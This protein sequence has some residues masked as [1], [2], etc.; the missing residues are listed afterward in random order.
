MS[1]NADKVA[2]R[3]KKLSDASKKAR[4][5][6]TLV[7]L[8]PSDGS[9]GEI[10]DLYAAHWRIILALY[11]DYVTGFDVDF[12]AGKGRQLNVPEVTALRS[13][14]LNLCHFSLP[15]MPKQ[16]RDEFLR[17]LE[18]EVHCFLHADNHLTVRR[19]GLELL[20]EW[21]EAERDP[22]VASSQVDPTVASF[23]VSAFDWEYFRTG[24]SGVV[25]PTTVVE[26]RK[27]RHRSFP[28]KARQTIGVDDERERGALEMLRNCFDRGQRVERPRWVEY[29]WAFFVAY[30]GPIL[31]PQE[32]FEARVTNRQLLEGFSQGVPPKIHAVVVQYLLR[33]AQ[34]RERIEKEKPGTSRL[35]CTEADARVVQLLLA[36]TPSITS[37]NPSDTISTVGALNLLHGWMHDTSI[38]HASAVVSD[39]LAVALKD[40]Q[41]A[42]YAVLLA[43]AE[44]EGSSTTVQQLAE[45]VLRLLVSVV[46]SDHQFSDDV[47]DTALLQL[48]VLIEKLCASAADGNAFAAE[49]LVLSCRALWA[50]VLRHASPTT[51]RFAKF[52]LPVA[53]RVQQK[54]RAAAASNVAC[55]FFHCWG[56]ILKTSSRSLVRETPKFEWPAAEAAPREDA[57]PLASQQVR[58]AIKSRLNDPCI[59]ERSCE[60]D[61]AFDFFNALLHETMTQ[62]A[63]DTPAARE[64]KC[65]ALCESTQIICQAATAGAVDLEPRSLVRLLAP[66]LLAAASSHVEGR[67]HSNLEVLAIE[68]TAMLMNLPSPTDEPVDTVLFAGLL[69]VVAG[70]LGDTNKSGNLDLTRRVLLALFPVSDGTTCF[71]EHPHHGSRCYEG[72][73]YQGADRLLETKTDGNTFAER[74]QASALLC[75]VWQI[76]FARFSPS[77]SPKVDGAEHLAKYQNFFKSAP[78]PACIGIAVRGVASLAEW[79]LEGVSDDDRWSQF[80]ACVELITTLFHHTSVRVAAATSSV[81]VSVLELARISVAALSDEMRSSRERDLG[82]VALVPTAGTVLWHLSQWNAEKPPSEAIVHQLRA[83]SSGVILCG[84]LDVALSGTTAHTIAELVCD[85]IAFSKSGA[86]AGQYA[87]SDPKPGEIVVV[88]ADEA[89]TRLNVPP[90]HTAIPGLSDA[91]AESPRAWFVEDVM[92]GEGEAA[93][94]DVWS[95]TDVLLG[96]LKRL[97]GNSNERFSTV[98]RMDGALVALGLNNT[99]ITK[100]FTGVRPDRLIIEA[101]TAH[102]VNS[103]QAEEVLHRQ[104]PKETTDAFRHLSA[105]SCSVALPADDALGHLLSASG[106]SGVEAPQPDDAARLTEDHEEGAQA[107][108]EPFRLCPPPSCDSR[109][110]ANTLLFH[111]GCFGTDPWSRSKPLSSGVR[112]QRHSALLGN[113]STDALPPCKD[114]CVITISH[115]VRDSA[116][117][118]KASTATTQLAEALGKREADDTFRWTSP[119]HEVVTV[120]GPMNACPSEPTGAETI[121]V[122]VHV[123]WAASLSMANAVGRVFRSTSSGG[124]HR[125]V[126]IVLTPTPGGAASR[127][128]HVFRR[129][130]ANVAPLGNAVPLPLPALPSFIRSA[131]IAASSSVH[132]GEGRARSEIVKSACVTAPELESF[133]QQLVPQLVSNT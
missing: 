122:S 130:A 104:H 48:G 65:T 42:H 38:P 23:V 31:Y 72:A 96:H 5:R 73:L 77:A 90:G 32:F 53:Y 17:V 8:A 112:P 57:I 101:N 84:A 28:P 69:N 95:A 7:P 3:V 66:Y 92:S 128:C 76:F 119:T 50:G 37:A 98:S 13:V 117:E 121:H 89:G 110:R 47:V 62:I 71:F 35:W 97:I 78:P 80:C 58:S 125:A 126:L 94:R 91:Q 106:W 46:T 79:C 61:G 133:E 41:L 54:C 6:F 86:C 81:F 14:L 9:P 20:L 19:H 108:F 60:V 127:V 70:A 113:E 12:E 49:T 22:T 75:K 56:A 18:T 39:V 36:V 33:V 10:A 116:D 16:A 103:W 123:V 51:P 30:L 129:G 25:L 2:A 120:L 67:A 115:A 34:V 68:T 131:A 111:F 21:H 102:S 55:Y 15:S 105:S 59:N 64:I 74:A 26:M 114:T 11:K 88:T 45:C 29:W 109:S 24:C 44:S 118:A 93:I 132:D 27:A 43:T 99:C 85:V 107:V 82:R 4:D 87:V 124:P 40:D 1:T 100:I 63:Q 52:L 83:L